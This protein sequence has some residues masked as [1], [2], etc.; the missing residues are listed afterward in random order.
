MSQQKDKNNESSGCPN[1]DE[2]LQS[3]KL[4][5][6]ESSDTYNTEKDHNN[7]T[8]QSCFHLYS[9]YATPFMKESA[10]FLLQYSKD[11]LDCIPFAYQVFIGTSLS[12]FILHDITRPIRLIIWAIHSILQFCI[13]VVGFAL[14]IGLGL[15]FATH[16]YE[17]L[18]SHAVSRIQEY[19]VNQNEEQGKKK[20]I[21]KQSGRVSKSRYSPVNIKQ[22]TIG[23]QDPESYEYHHLMTKSG[24]IQPELPEGSIQRGDSTSFHIFRGQLILCSSLPSSIDYNTIGMRGPTIMQHMW[25]N[26]PKEIN[27]QFGILIDLIIRDY[28]VS[29]VG[30]IDDAI[31]YKDPALTNDKPHAGATTGDDQSVSSNILHRN[32]SQTCKDNS[33]IKD[34]TKSQSRLMKQMMITSTAQLK[35]SPFINTINLALVHLIGQLCTTAVDNV[36]VVDLILI[37]FVK[38]I[39]KTLKFYRRARKV[40]ILQ[41]SSYRRSINKAKDLATDNNDHRFLEIAIIKELLITKRLHKAIVFGLDVPSLLFSDPKGVKAPLHTKEKSTELHTTI[42]DDFSVLHDR[43]FNTPLIQECELDYNRVLANRIC[44]KLIPATDLSSPIMKTFA[45]EVVAGS[46][47]SSIMSFFVPESINDYMIKGFK[48]YLDQAAE[49]L[50]T[51]SNHNQTVQNKED[52]NVSVN[53]KFK[54]DFDFDTLIKDDKVTR[55]LDDLDQETE[56][57]V[58]NGTSIMVTEEQNTIFDIDNAKEKNERNGHEKIAVVKNYAK[59]SIEL[60]NGDEGIETDKKI[61]LNAQIESNHNNQ[62]TIMDERSLAHKSHANDMDSNNDYFFDENEKHFKEVE[63]IE[64]FHGDFDHE[65]ERLDEENN[66]AD[67]EYSMIEDGSEEFV[68]TEL[69][70]D[71]SSEFNIEEVPLDIKELKKSPPN[72][73]VLALPE[74]IVDEPG[75]EY[76]AQD[77]LPILTLAVM[78]VQN[79]VQEGSKNEEKETNWENRD[80]KAA[81]CHL[82]LVIE[83]AIQHG[84]KNVVKSRNILLEESPSK[85]KELTL[86]TSLIDLL[87]DMTMNIDAFDKSISE[88]SDLQDENQEQQI[89]HVSPKKTSQDLFKHESSTLRTVIVAWMQTGD[90]YNAIRVFTSSKILTTHFYKTFAIFNSDDLSGAFCNQLKL[91]NGVDILVD[92]MAVL[93]ADC[94]DVQSL[95]GDA[96]SSSPKDTSIS[97]SGGMQRKPEHN[98]T[99]ETSFI[100]QAAA[101]GQ[102]QLPGQNQ[103]TLLAS[104]MKANMRNK[105]NR[106]SRWVG[107]TNN[108]SHNKNGP[109]VHVNVRK[110]RSKIE[111]HLDFH[112]NNLFA[113]KSRSERIKRYDA[114]KKAKLSFA[115]TSSGEYKIIEMVCSNK[116]RKIHRDLHYFSRV[117]YGSTL[118]LSIDEEND[119]HQFCNI[120]AETKCG[121]R[122]VEVPDDDSSF[123]LKAQVRC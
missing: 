23:L 21:K 39:T 118:S 32:E 55:E 79:F 12:A 93:E 72:Q 67:T 13:G 19:E 49:S 123:L 66:L 46:I 59:S 16:V 27:E 119:N 63:Q 54:N 18:D 81:V 88:K 9:S 35:Q 105:R 95:A 2:S 5:D 92:T 87:M 28:V 96:L 53:D 74:N 110:D 98:T 117:M 61:D 112:R 103:I 90:I 73:S 62:S 85:V 104:N 1:F 99:S 26:L 100:K 4:L 69:D 57:H 115:M 80:C 122:M 48:T 51:E 78:D 38:A 107:V 25:P 121:R 97:Q 64:S 41:Q 71:L 47:L 91:L 29:W 58:R 44:R 24:Y 6:S 68:S 11:R 114:W 106:L 43:L 52:D 77:I 102:S 7:A 113:N 3:K 76:N 75:D 109:T 17:T 60:P 42:S 37:K 50:S 65:N 116:S 40:A 22:C 10:I 82:V 31:E 83:A 120:L 56:P 20:T 70:N 45:V 33:N 86:G 101:F 15:G 111:N 30:S 108:L 14:S 84:R 8:L 94:I 36:N 89:A 34:N